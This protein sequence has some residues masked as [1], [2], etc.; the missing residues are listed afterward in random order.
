MVRSMELDRYSPREQER[1]ADL[2]RLLP[3]GRRSVLEIGARDGYFSV[4]L[5]EHF[6]QVTALDLEK[7]RIDHPGI[8][9][10]RGDVTA[11]Q[12]G[13]GSFD[14]VLC[15]E[16]LE[17]IPGQGLRQ[18]AAE[19]QRVARCEVVV[20]VPYRQDLRVGRTRCVHCGQRNPLWGHVN[21]FDRRQLRRLFDRCRVVEESL[22]GRGIERTNFL[23]GWLMDLAGDPYGVYEQQEPCIHCGFPLVRPAPPK[24]WRWLAAKASDCLVQLQRRLMR[25]QPIWLHAVLAKDDCPAG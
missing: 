9:Q 8:T 18:A 19:L 22:V 15:S 14:V 20:G 12:F 24:S 25:P 2:M 16:V 4:L 5:R 21:R 3:R 23:S 11:L 1:I 7:P 6:Q 10:V 13:D 17:H